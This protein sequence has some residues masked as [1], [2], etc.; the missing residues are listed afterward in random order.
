MRA[1]LAGVF[2]GTAV[3]T[4]SVAFAESKPAAPD[5][6]AKAVA[7][8]LRMDKLG[9]ALS[10]LMP[11]LVST[12]RF[13]DP[14][15]RK[16]ILQNVRTLKELTHGMPGDAS[17]VTKDPSVAML[18]QVFR[19]DL[20]EAEW[21]IKDGH[22]EYA[23]SLLFNVANTCINC[24]TRNDQG[25]QFP[26]M[27]LAPQEKQLSPFEL[28]T[29]HAATRRYAQAMA[30]YLVVVEDPK[31]PLERGLDWDR[32]VQASLTLAVRT[33]NSPEQALAVVERVV[34]HPAAPLFLK[35]NALA[36]RENITRW[37]EEG[38]TPGDDEAQFQKANRL[39]E[40]AL[41][42]SRYRS[43]RGNAVLYLRASRLLHDLLGKNPDGPKAQDQLLLLGVAYEG[44][45]ELELYALHPMMFEACIRKKPHAPTALMCFERYEAAMY[46]QFTGS[47]GYNLPGD[48]RARLAELQ[49]LAA[50]K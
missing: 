46:Q 9:A 16:R 15:N 27:E 30:E 2:L 35:Q 8:R 6:A 22:A 14:K 12:P 13:A 28:A 33:M 3:W 42:G 4:A 50:P 38:A 21:A 37:K 24:H 29:L 45:A 44:L 48:V 47:G 5:A 11:D 19:D 10:A 31:A 43:A 23:Q 20:D 17:G 25:V 41:L 36:W 32:A 34:A 7:W 1:T 39:L 26:T 49:K 40:E 18:T